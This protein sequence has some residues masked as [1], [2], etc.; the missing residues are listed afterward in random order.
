MMSTTNLDG[1][2]AV[3]TGAG[4]GLGRAE[5]L[6]LAR[7][8]A[9][10]V[11]NDFGLTLDGAPASDTPAQ[12]VADEIKGL[13]GAAVVHQGDVA[14]WDDANSLISTAIEEFGSLDILVNNAGI[15]R[16]RMI[17]SM[18]PEDFDAVIRVHLK[19]HFNTLRAA[20]AYWRDAS[21]SADAPV[22]ARVVN[23]ASEA[24]LIGSPGQPNYAAAKAGIVALTLATAQSCAKYG[25][26]ANAICPRART[27]MTE[28]VFGAASAE[29][30]PLAPEHVAPLVAFLSSPAADA[31]NG[32]VFVVHGG[33]V[34]LVA[35]P[36]YETQ[37]STASGHWDVEELAAEMQTFF[38]DRDPRRSFAAVSLLQQQVA[39]S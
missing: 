17:F 7:Q 31:V 8:G 39:A 28:G 9:R 2:V 16:D 24:F 3:V 25:V 33:F 20:T 5:A 30:D 6:E 34:G 15:L 32:Q 1:K 22:Y 4:R 13:G 10:I 11:V 38:T 26:R 18:S 27:R 21:K 23:T 37:F 19:G 29:D 35:A 12:Q 14:D 36:E